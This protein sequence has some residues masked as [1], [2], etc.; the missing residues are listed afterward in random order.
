MFKS[1]IERGPSLI[2]RCEM[3]K[4]VRD[5]GDRLRDLPVSQRVANSEIDGWFIA[6]ANVIVQA[7]GE[8]SQQIRRW[9]DE[10][11]S[12][13]DLDRR[14]ALQGNFHEIESIIREISVMRGLLIEFQDVID[15][16]SR[17]LEMER[18]DNVVYHISGGNFVGSQIGGVANTMQT[19]VEQ[20]RVN[21]YSSN[22]EKE[23][24]E[25]LAKLRQAIE[26]TNDLN[27]AEK[28]AAATDLAMLTDELAKPVEEQDE[29]AKKMFWERLKNVLSVSAGLGNLAA[30]VAKLSGLA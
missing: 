22:E 30:I 8:D 6:A 14:E 27:S 12:L 28:T 10:R 15:A 1:I 17:K 5:R 29:N 2:T 19:Y 23:L 13:S 25:N 18:R 24:K 7:F 26:E 9:R 20:L 16:Q 4:Q 21:E 11:K 3:L